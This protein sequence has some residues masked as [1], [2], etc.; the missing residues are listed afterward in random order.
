MDDIRAD[1][2]RSYR[3]FLDAFGLEPPTW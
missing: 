2:A 3:P 1:R